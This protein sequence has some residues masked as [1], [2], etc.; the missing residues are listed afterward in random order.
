MSEELDKK[1]EVV[2]TL[3]S[4]GSS[5]LF[6]DNTLTHFSNK[7]HTPIILKPSNDNYITLQEIGISLE[8]GNIKI[9]FNTPAITYI[10]WDI[11]HFL[12]NLPDYPN[13]LTKNKIQR[14]CFL[15]TYEQN[16]S[17]FLL[18]IQTVSVFT[19]IKDILKMKFI[20]QKLSKTN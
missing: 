6:K 3:L 4:N 20:T 9:P 12:Y 11:S 17:T 13:D 15:S 8:S 16:K 5:H 7:L 19:V 2:V 10:E 1:E 18:T 14:E